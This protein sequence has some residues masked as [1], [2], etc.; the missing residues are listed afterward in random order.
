[1]ITNF[2][3]QWLLD[4]TK[5]QKPIRGT[6][7]RYPMDDRRYAHY[8]YFL[9][10]EIDGELAFVVHYGQKWEKQRITQEEYT[11][12]VK[13]NQQG[14]APYRSVSHTSDGNGYM[15]YVGVPNPIAIVRP[16]NTVE[17][18]ADRYYQGARQMINTWSPFRTF[19]NNEA[20]RGGTIIRQYRNSPWQSPEVAH[21]FFKGLRLNLDGLKLHPSSE[22]ELYK[23]RV[24]R[25]VAK[26][27]MADYVYMFDTA[28]PFISNMDMSMLKELCNDVMDDRDSLVT[29]GCG[30]TFETLEERYKDDPVNFMLLHFIKL[31][32]TPEFFSRITSRHDYMFDYS[33]RRYKDNLVDYVKRKARKHVLS[34]DNG[35]LYYEQVPSGKLPPSNDW[36]YKLVVDGIETK[37]FA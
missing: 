33:L 29:E 7:N 27:I 14:T 11:E 23:T 19:V 13:H 31:A 2:N 5:Y 32:V 22:Y 6:T 30:S 8:K 36:G 15:M 9:A 24:N 12:A 28:A 21:P 18:C 34:H 16:D 25:K 10:E 1:M 17:F 3:Y 35:A 37:Q 20:H 4:I 26:Q